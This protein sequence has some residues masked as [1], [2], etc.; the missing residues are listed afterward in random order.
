M[1]LKYEEQFQHFTSSDFKMVGKQNY[2]SPWL[3]HIGGEPVI[4]YDSS[5]TNGSCLR[6]RCVKENG[7]VSTSAV[8]TKGSHTFPDGQIEVR[9]RFKG[10]DSSWPAIWLKSRVGDVEYEIDLCEYFGDGNKAKVGIFMPKHLK[11]G[12]TRLFRPKENV[13]IDKHGW[14]TFACK[15]DAD[16]IILHV[17]RK[18]VIEY[19]RKGNDP[20]QFPLTEEA[21]NFY[22]ILSMQYGHGKEKHSQLPLWMDIDYV[23]YWGEDTNRNGRIADKRTKK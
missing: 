7:E 19:K 11:W 2:D 8:W 6:L 4:L 1:E 15:W 16:K 20:K 14:N 17:N 9:A 12:L 13:K 10:G 22:L 3:K 21:R 5:A 18:P 23:K